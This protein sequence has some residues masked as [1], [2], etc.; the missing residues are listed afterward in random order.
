M[1]QTRILVIDDEP[2]I[3]L[4]CERI[5]LRAGYYVESTTDPEKAIQ[6]SKEQAF[7]LFL[8]DVRMPGVFDVYAYVSKL[9]EFQSTAPAIVLMTGFGTVE[10]AVKALR[11][12]VAGLMLKPFDKSADL[13]ETVEH[14]LIDHEL[15]LDR[16]Y[17][18]RKNQKRLRVFLCHSKIDK[19]M[20]RTLY[21]SLIRERFID[22][23]LDEK[24]LA[25]GA[26]WNLEITRAVKECDVVLV[27]LSRDS[28]DKKGYIHKEIKMALDVA[29]EQ[30]ENTIYIIPTRLDDCIVPDRLAKWQ[31]VD[32]FEEKGYEKLLKSLKKR[33]HLLNAK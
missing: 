12:G 24:K 31:W 18:F 17:L 2:G 29:D 28:V 25:P 8:I 23:W 21:E 20:I 11:E 30:P 9:L 32:L 10:T 27:C 5:L 22:P 14:A 19:D 7:D 6:I 16:G 26:D 4:L 3:A 33:A 15:R 1:S 13:L